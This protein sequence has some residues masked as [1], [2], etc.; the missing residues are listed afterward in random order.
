MGASLMARNIFNQPRKD[1]N[2][3]VAPSPA[4]VVPNAWPLAPNAGQLSGEPGWT[5][6]VFK[7]GEDRESTN[8]LPIIQRPYRPLHFYGNTVRRWYYR[9]NPLPL[10]ADLIET[11]RRIIGP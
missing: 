7:I 5:S 2:E 1:E 9:G 11:G 10:P 4:P 3:S 6:R 8:S